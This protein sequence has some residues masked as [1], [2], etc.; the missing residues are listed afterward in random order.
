[1]LPLLSGRALLG[2]SVLRGAVVRGRLGV[3]GFLGVRLRVLLRA[4]LGDDLFGTLV[5][6]PRADGLAFSGL[7]FS[8]LAF[9]GLGLGGLALGGLALGGLAVNLAER[10]LA[11]GLGVRLLL[12][13]RGFGVVVA[14]APLLGGR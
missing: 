3:A 14:L 2:R 1:A 4:L 6:D 8:G 5:H 12:G 13:E 10:A 11:L 9:S 7:A